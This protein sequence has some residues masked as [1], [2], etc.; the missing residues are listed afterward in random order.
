MFSEIFVS[1]IYNVKET[2]SK[3]FSNVFCL[4]LNKYFLDI[5]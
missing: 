1:I 5:F 4:A 3:Y 2:S